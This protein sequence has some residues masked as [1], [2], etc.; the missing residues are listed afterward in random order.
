M[1]NKEYTTEKTRKALHD[2]NEAMNLLDSMP[3]WIES[4][5]PRDNLREHIEHAAKQLQIITDH[6][7]ARDKAELTELF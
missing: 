2:L 6:F 3:A 5:T 4:G 1:Y 7:D